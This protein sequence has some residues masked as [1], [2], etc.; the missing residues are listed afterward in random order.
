MRSSS[1]TI[2]SPGTAGRNAK[3][4]PLSFTPGDLVLRKVFQT[5]QEPGVGA[6]GSKWEGP[7]KVT[8]IVR[9]GVYELED[10]GGKP[11]S[12]PWNAE[13]LKK[14]ISISLY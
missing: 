9:S 14:I 11:L 8:R 2:G 6:F 3:V 13:H 10:L 7:Y 5:T 4:R 1:N 12:H